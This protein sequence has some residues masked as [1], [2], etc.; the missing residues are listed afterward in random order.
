MADVKALSV[1]EIPFTVKGADYRFTIPSF[2]FDNTLYTAE[3]ALTKPELLEQLVDIHRLKDGLPEVG[4]GL[5]E[6]VS[7][8]VV[9]SKAKNKALLPVKDVTDAISKAATAAEVDAIVG[10][11]VRKTVTDAAA[12]RKA[13]L[14]A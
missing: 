2:I 9:E 12:K 7:G 3:E 8:V 5:L 11:D 10:D 14:S 6:L 1:P 4:A 13:E